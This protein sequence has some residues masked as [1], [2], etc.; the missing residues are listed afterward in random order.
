MKN[1]SRCLQCGASLGSDAG[2]CANCGEARPAAVADADPPV[3]PGSAE[4][5]MAVRRA[6]RR[7]ALLQ[8]VY[9]VVAA[10]LTVST[11]REEPEMM[12]AIVPRMLF[13]MLGIAAVLTALSFWASVHPWAAALFGLAFYLGAHL[14][15]AMANPASLTRGPLIKIVMLVLLIQAVRAGYRAGPANADGYN[16][17]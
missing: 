14:L 4:Q 10:A 8:A 13:F 12:R 11:F 16:G 6:L 7:A 5:A 15:A 17:R 3:K 2:F 9:A 1:A